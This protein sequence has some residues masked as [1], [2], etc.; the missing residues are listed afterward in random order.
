MEIVINF[1]LFIKYSLYSLF[2]LVI[3]VFVLIIF[4]QLKRLLR[5]PE[6]MGMDRQSIKRHW[7]EVE[8]MIKKPGE[9]T[10]KLAILEADKLLDQ[11]LKSMAMPGQTMGERLKVA[12]YKYSELSKVW[13][14]HKLRN[15]LVHEASFSISH[16]NAKSA[17][18]AYAR[19]L[20]QLGV[21]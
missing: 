16:G 10:D 19:A 15:Q 13:W 6:L 9:M 17:I 14:A 12:S 3:I 20:K 8:Q 21:L 2:A 7:E 1:P 18:R 5:R 4:W 11:V